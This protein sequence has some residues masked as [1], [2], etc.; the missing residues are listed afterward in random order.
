M[1]IQ[2]IYCRNKSFKKFLSKRNQMCAQKNSFAPNLKT[3]TYR[4]ITTSRIYKDVNSK[5]NSNEDPFENYEI[6]YDD[7]ERF[8][9]IT[10]I[11]SG[12]YSVVFLGR[13]DGENSCAVKTLRNVPFVKIQREVCIHRQVASLPNVIS[14]VGVVKDPLTSTIS[15]ITKYQKSENPRVLFSRM[16]IDDIRVLM[17]KLLRSLDACAKCGIMHRDV[18]PGNVLI[19]PNRRELELIDWGLAD[20]YFPEKPYTTHVSTMRYK[21]PELLMNYQYYDYGVD[22]WGAGCV[23]A[24]M[25]VKFPF[26]EGRN[27]DEMVVQVANVC[28]TSAITQYAEKYGLNISSQVSALLPSIS[29]PGWQRTLHSIKPQKMDEDAISLMKKLLIVDHEERIT[30]AE[31]LKEP[32]FDSIRDEMMR[33]KQ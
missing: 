25:L 14:L 28:G 7:I 1:T 9:L 20:Y 21:A 32:F 33:E 26:F 2:F 4:K 31:A 17:F 30:A 16:D 5:L 3:P 22:V 8:E 27:L 23:M 19:S 13:Y 12:K 29:S 10:P 11:G 15:L 18:K 24:E 6:E